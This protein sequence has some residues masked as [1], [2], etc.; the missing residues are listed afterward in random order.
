MPRKSGENS[1]RTFA[2]LP[3]IFGR[4]ILVPLWVPSPRNIRAK[5]GIKRLEKVIYRINRGAPPPTA[6]ITG[7]LLSILLHRAGR[8]RHPHERPAIAR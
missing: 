4:T 1:R 5:L 7:D 2:D 8:R 6:A 3:R